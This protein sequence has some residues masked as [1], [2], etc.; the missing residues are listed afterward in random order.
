MAKSINTVAAQVSERIGP[1][2][3]AALAMKF[4]VPDVPSFRAIALGAVDV[5][6]ENLTAAYLPFARG[7][8]KPE[9]YAIEK[10]T[11]RN[12]EVLFEHKRTE[13]E[14]VM[15]EHA[16]KDMN[17]LLY[18]VMHSRY[19]PA[20]QPGAAAT[21]PAKPAPPMIGAM[22]GLSATRRSSL[23]ASG[24]AMTITGPM[25]QVTG[26]FGSGRNLERFHDLGASGLAHSL[27]RRRLPGGHLR[28]RARPAQFLC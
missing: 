5:T 7:G 8:L 3:V 16:A 17:H 14:R 22:P 27:H 24:S 18:Q 19:W 10:V 23:S 25:D 21:P 6:L 26:G 2:K 11:N 28:L 20:G 15:S 13:P 9:P 12:G 1:S 4:G